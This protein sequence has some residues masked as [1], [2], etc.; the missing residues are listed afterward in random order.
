MLRE[1]NHSV[2]VSKVRCNA[3]DEK[4]SG[5]VKDN[6]LNKLYGNKYRIP[7][8]LGILNDHGAFYPKGF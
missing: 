7:I 6:K 8:D 5:V 2:N 1:G 4:T 3:G